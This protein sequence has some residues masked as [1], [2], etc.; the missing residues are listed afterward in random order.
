MKYS[1]E[2]ARNIISKSIQVRSIEFIGCGNHSEA[3][4]INNEMVVKLPK[5]RKA[6][7]CLKV[8]MQVLQ[9]LEQKVPLDI[10]NV[11]FNNTFSVGHEE[12][13]YFASKRLYGKKL[14]KAE[15]LMPDERTLFQNAEI[16]ANFLYCLHNQK[17]FCPSKEKIWFCCTVTSALT[18][19]C[20]MIKMWCAEFL[21]LQIAALENLKVIFLIYLMTK[22]TRNSAQI[23]ERRFLAYMKVFS[24]LVNETISLIEIFKQNIN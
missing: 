5:H 10:P 1:I 22:I 8:E 20:L 23:L 12:F 6:S 19:Y 9:G 18:T 11:I 15:F 13:V 4:C 17:I 3:F 14:S 2:R 7:K 16:I 24:I 21:I